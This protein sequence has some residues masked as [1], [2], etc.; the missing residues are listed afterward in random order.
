MK[1]E[2]LRLALC[3]FQ[4]HSASIDRAE[5]NSPRLDVLD[6]WLDVRDI[7]GCNVQEQ[8]R[9]MQHR[10]FV[11]QPDIALHRRR[12]MIMRADLCLQ[13]IEKRSADVL[14]VI[15]RDD[16]LVTVLSQPLRDLVQI[17]DVVLDADL[18]ANS[19]TGFPIY[20]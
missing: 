13:T 10:S 19:E 4:H 5:N 18:N 14:D 2:W 8:D 16:L 3:R 17:I 7:A 9:M 15:D 12:H 1:V 20:S 6:Y 11:V